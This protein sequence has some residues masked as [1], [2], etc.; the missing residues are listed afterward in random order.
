MHILFLCTILINVFG[1]DVYAINEQLKDFAEG[2]LVYNAQCMEIVN[3]RGE[4]T[5]SK[6][7]YDAK[8]SKNETAIE[9]YEK[10]KRKLHNINWEKR[11]CFIYQDNGVGKIEKK[12]KLKELNEL[13]N[14]LSIELRMMQ[15]K[16]EITDPNLIFPN[17][18]NT[19]F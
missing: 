18:D 9:K 17:F 15:K 7:T 11:A 3:Q 8:K 5:L 16:E 19:K 1:H 6:N 10:L 14:S 12:D 2:P 13:A 4:K